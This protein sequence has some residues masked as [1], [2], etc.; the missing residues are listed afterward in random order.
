MLQEAALNLKATTMKIAHTIKKDSKMRQ[1]R[2]QFISTNNR[3]SIL[4]ETKH[5]H[6]E[7]YRSWLSSNSGPLPRDQ[8]CRRRYDIK[9]IINQDTK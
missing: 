2:R 1:L 4:F 9:F 7:K 6:F 3:P 8:V 5:F